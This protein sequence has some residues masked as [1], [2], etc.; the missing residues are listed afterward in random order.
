MTKLVVEKGVEG[1]RKLEQ[2]VYNEERQNWAVLRNS[3]N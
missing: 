1:G 3:L 2:C